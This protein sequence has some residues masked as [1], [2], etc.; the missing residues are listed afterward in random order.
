M[1]WN[2]ENL[3]VYLNYN[4]QND[5]VYKINYF[6]NKSDENGNSNTL[7]KIAN[8]D[9][10]NLDDFIPFE[11]LTNEIV[12]NWIKD[13]LGQSGIDDLETE[14]DNSLSLMANTSIKTL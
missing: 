2:I 4:N 11:D 8:F 13:D 5:V 14:L 7:F 12:L 3:T 10:T 9:L 6:V 1:I